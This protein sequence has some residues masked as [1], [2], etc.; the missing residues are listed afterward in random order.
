MRRLLR[1]FGLLSTLAVA[2]ATLILTIAPAAAQ[3]TPSAYFGTAT[4]DGVNLSAGD[5][6]TATIEGDSFTG[7]AVTI[8]ETDSYYTIFI[9]MAAGKDYAGKT[10]TFSFSGATA[11][12]TWSV[13]DSRV[14]LAF[15]T[16]VAATATA[17]PAT[18]VPATGVPATG[19]PATPPAT[20]GSAPG[21]GA[22]WGAIAVGMAIMGLGALLLLR[23]KQT[24]RG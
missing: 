4:L 19:V 5:V 7:D 23:R 21:S 6:V 15:V 1:M 8:D 10:I 18:G 2:G 16:P 12:T 22:L 9:P 3:V 13:G 24:A 17:V 14:D 11:T 20:G